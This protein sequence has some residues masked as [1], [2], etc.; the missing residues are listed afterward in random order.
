MFTCQNESGKIS[1][2]FHSWQGNA[3]VLSGGWVFLCVFFLIFPS[4]WKGGGAFIVFLGAAST[5][6]CGLAAPRC[7]ALRGALAARAGLGAAPASA[8]LPARPPAAPGTRTR[9]AFAG[10]MGDESE[11]SLEATSNKSGGCRKRRGDK[12]VA[13][14]RWDPT[15]KQP[16]SIKNPNLLGGGGVGNPCRCGRAR[17]D[18]ELPR[19][20]CCPAGGF[21]SRLD[22]AARGA[23]GAWAQPRAHGPVLPRRQRPAPSW[24]QQG[25]SLRRHSL[26][27]RPGRALPRGFAAPLGEGLRAGPELWAAGWAG[28]AVPHPPAPRAVCVYDANIIPPPEKPGLP[29]E[30]RVS[31][32]NYSASC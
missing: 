6:G 24:A 19:S 14:K 4:F 29:H 18:P 23:G 31:G 28:L 8:A 10:V 12:R 3:F 26:A 2:A 7:A 11:S 32:F 21:A 30:L 20:S 9:G 1:V 22:V 16:P 13:A 17:P 27:A 15:N 5:C 25:P